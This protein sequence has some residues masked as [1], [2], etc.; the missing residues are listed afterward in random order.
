MQTV[1]EKA[2]AKKDPVR[3]GA[4]PAVKVA[5]QVALTLSTRSGKL[6]VVLPDGTALD[7]CDPT[8]RITTFFDINTARSEEPRAKCVRLDQA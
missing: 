8:I 3:G 2:I 5:T 6:H 4:G 1:V 7:S